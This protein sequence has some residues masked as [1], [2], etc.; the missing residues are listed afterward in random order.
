MYEQAETALVRRLNRSFDQI[1]Q[2]PYSPPNIKRLQ[3]TLT[4][5]FRHRVGDWRVIY[6]VDEEQRTVTIL[7][8]AHR[9]Q[10]YR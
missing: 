3:G 7:F 10:A 9:S 6:T 8:I 4:G 5:Q 2:T 1:S